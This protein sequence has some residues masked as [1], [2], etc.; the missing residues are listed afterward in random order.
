ML[1]RL[2]W[3]SISLR[4]VGAC[5]LG[6]VPWT[7]SPQHAQRKLLHRLGACIICECCG[8]SAG[9]PLVGWREAFIMHGGQNG[10]HG[11]SAIAEMALCHGHGCRQVARLSEAAPVIAYSADTLEGQ[12][13]NDSARFEGHCCVPAV[14]RS[15]PRPGPRLVQVRTV[16]SVCAA[17]KRTSS[18]WFEHGSTNPKTPFTC[19]CRSTRRIMAHQSKLPWRKHTRQW[20]MHV[21]TTA[22]TMH[23]HGCGLPNVQPTSKGSLNGPVRAVL[24]G[25]VF[26]ATAR[27]H[28]PHV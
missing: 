10:Q 7:A 20:H 17:C 28:V 12:W 23:M 16:A 4:S 25:C 1:A 24:T 21:P 18:S 27:I 15:A 11:P 22:T 2:I 9:C 6:I 26:L 14:L 8:N 13:R 3:A 19:A 5:D